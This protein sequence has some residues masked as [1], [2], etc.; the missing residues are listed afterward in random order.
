MIYELFMASP[1]PHGFGNKGHCLKQHRSLCPRV[2]RKFTCQ[3]EIFWGQSAGMERWEGVS[4][5]KVE[6][7]RVRL[8]C[9]GVPLSRWGY[10]CC[11]C[12]PRHSPLLPQPQWH[13]CPILSAPLSSSGSCQAWVEGCGLT[14]ARWKIELYQQGLTMGLGICH[15][16]GSLWLEICRDKAFWNPGC[17]L[18]S[19]EEI[20]L[21]ESKD[22]WKTTSSVR[23]SIMPTAKSSSKVGLFQT[24]L[25]LRKA[26]PN[27]PYCSSDKAFEPAWLSFGTWFYFSSLLWTLSVG[28]RARFPD[29]LV[30]SCPGQAS[31]CLPEITYLKLLP[32]SGPLLLTT[33][34]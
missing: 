33:S 25:F 8:R 28:S 24:Y 16:L 18:I 27:S 7:I 21:L 19:I 30:L 3:R 29:P 22:D 4:K 5:K 32:F 13:Q 6:N 15:L 2:G 17:C 31:V 23:M 20:M 14:S 12:L 26:F 10:Y 34:L 11:H 9:T 1:C